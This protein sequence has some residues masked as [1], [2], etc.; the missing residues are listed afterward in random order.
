MSR[1]DILGIDILMYSGLFVLF[2]VCFVE[3]HFPY[4]ACMR[5]PKILIAAHMEPLLLTWNNL[6]PSM[7]KKLHPLQNV[8]WNY[9]SIQ[10]FI[11]A[12]V[13]VWE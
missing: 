6:N 9:L 13:E 2:L 1:H 10:N 7:D 3:Y 11:G 8:G 12:S 5:L 4:Y